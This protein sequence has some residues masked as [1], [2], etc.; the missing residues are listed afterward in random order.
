M[1]EKTKIGPFRTEKIAPEGG[2]GYL[3]ALGLAVTAAFYLGLFATFGL[4]FNDFLISVGAGTSSVTLI[5]GVFKL[6][7]SFM[8]LL[9]G[10]LI[11]KFTLRPV[12]LFGAVVYVAGSISVIF[13]TSVTHLIISIGILQGSGMGLMIPVVY[14]TFNQYFVKKRIFVMSVTQIVKGALVTVQPILV[15]YLMEKY[16]FRGTLAVLALMQGHVIIALYLMQPVEWHYRRTQVPIEA[17]ESFINSDKKDVE[18]D[19]VSKTELDKINEEDDNEMMPIKSERSISYVLPQDLND[20]NSIQ[21]RVSSIM[22]LGDVRGVFV[23]EEKLAKKGIWQKIV[24]LLDLN[25]LNDFIYL[26]VVIA[27]T[28][29]WYVD[30]TL[31]ALLPM[32]L[33]E[34]GFSKNDAA[35]ILSFGSG[36]DLCSRIFL[37]IVSYWIELRARYIFLTAAIVIVFVRIGLMYVFDFYGIGIV[38]VVIGFLRAWFFVTPPLIIA[39]LLE[40]E[41]FAAGLGLFL[42]IEGNLAFLL[43]PLTGWI[44]D[45][46]K[47]YP[48]CFNTLTLIFGL[49]TVS[50]IGEMIWFRFFA[51]K[52]KRVEQQ[53]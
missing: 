12:G 52:T 40:S 49:C 8:G 42:F 33:F 48:I 35:K 9:V 46:T 21:K 6:C 37:A 15:Q 38:V 25:L 16:G 26:N 10:A 17:S 3:V 13:A 47:S 4:L 44:R 51:Q 18:I 19:V 45:T 5:L 1:I 41:K 11:K 43:S 20:F 32:Y 23:L 7:S 24:K 27:I 30:N 2:F 29:S 34:L 31:F 22:S 14:G 50:W 36:A 28:M 39:E 53:P